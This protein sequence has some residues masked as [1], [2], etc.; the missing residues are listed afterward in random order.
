MEWNGMGG[1]PSS[2]CSRLVQLSFKQRNLVDIKTMLWYGVL[3]SIT[4]AYLTALSGVRSAKQHDVPHHSRRMIIACTIVGIWLIAYVCKQVVFGRE[5][6]GGTA[7]QYWVLYVPLLTIHVLLALTTIG[8]GSFN[9]YTGLTRLRMGTGVGAMVAGV[10]RHRLLGKILVG[11]F[12][13]TLV[14]AYGVYLM[15]FVWF[16]AS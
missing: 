12:S 3:V 16:P 11:T 8:L 9:L 7:Q 5:V 13:G 14:T 4:G 15:L 6:F 2:P 10:S 1:P